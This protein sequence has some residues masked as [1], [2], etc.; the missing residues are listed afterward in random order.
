MR[1]HLLVLCCASLALAFESGEQKAKKR[2]LRS[3]AKG[4]TIGEYV[5]EFKLVDI[6]C[7]ACEATARSIEK[8][9]N[10][11]KHR[12]D[13]VGRLEMMY[14]ACETVDLNIPQ[15]MPP[16]EEG[17]PR[18]LHFFPA[19]GASPGELDNLH[20]GLQSYCNV[21]VEEYEDE[22]EAALKKS[23]AAATSGILKGVYE[24]KVSICVDSTSACT[25][26]QLNT[27]SG[28]RI[29]GMRNL[30]P[31]KQAELQEMINAMKQG[32]AK[33]AKDEM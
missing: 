14:T 4:L 12:G 20:L 30:P 1:A 2:A 5:D 6:T 32:N 18:V 16:N 24:M 8:E 17:G 21:L 10:L 26:D 19:K 15:V 7:A 22:L 33:E 29:G 13:T 27:I 25:N 9:M 11:G 31:A 3:A 23:E 28:H